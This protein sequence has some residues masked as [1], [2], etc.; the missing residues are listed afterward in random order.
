MA[1]TAPGWYDD[2]RGALR[3]WDGAQWTEHVQTPDPEPALDEQSASASD[4]GQPETPVEYDASARPRSARRR[5]THSSPPPSELRPTQR[6]R[7]SP[8][9]GS[10]APTTDPHPRAPSDAA[11]EGGYPPSA[12]PGYPG[13]FPGGPAPSGAFISATEPKKSKLWILW[14]VL[15]VVLLGI[16]VLAT[17]FIPILIGMFG[18]AAGGGAETE[19]ETA[20]VAAVELYDEAWRHSRLRQVGQATTESLRDTLG[21]PDCETFTEASAGFHRLGG[22]LPADG[23]VGRDRGR[24]RSP[25]RRPRRTTASSTRTAIRP[26]SRSRTRTTTPTVV[27]P[28]GDGWAVNEAVNA[29]RTESS[30]AAGLGRRPARRRPAERRD[31]A[32]LTGPGRSRR[33]RRAPPRSCRRG[34]WRPVRAR[35]GSG[36]AGAR[37]RSGAALR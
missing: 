15:G 25:S 21:L 36:R 11:P 19:D 14:V 30:G 20:A 3:W 13:G 8:A 29:G 23:R 10:G 31:R 16:V 18:N 28:S 26:R 27:V 9:A 6:R 17:V 35:A 1:T 24:D 37:R 12:P 22:G 34:H 33:R 32:A 4:A 2:G 7:A 5:W